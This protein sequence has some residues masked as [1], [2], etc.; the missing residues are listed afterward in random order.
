MFA[1]KYGLINLHLWC[2]LKLHF[3]TDFILIAQFNKR[4]NLISLVR[5]LFLILEIIFTI[6]I[7][8]ILSLSEDLLITDIDDVIRI[9]K[10]LST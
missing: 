4:D 10:V 1:G 3:E 6:T 5:F 9:V 2:N 7:F 8:T